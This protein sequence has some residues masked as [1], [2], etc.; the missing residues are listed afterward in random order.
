MAGAQQL[1][2]MLR[3]GVVCISTGRVRPLPVTAR[4]STPGSGS[5]AADILSNCTI[6]TF[7]PDNGVRLSDVDRDFSGDGS[8]SSFD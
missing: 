4:L 5:I 7:T 1:Q 2:A 8:P 6:S 3:G